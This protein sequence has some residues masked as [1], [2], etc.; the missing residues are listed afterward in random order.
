MEKTD[1]VLA[2]VRQRGP[3]IPS[4]VSSEIKTDILLASAILSDLSSSGKVKVSSLKMGGSPF[5]YCE[6][7]EELLQNH[8]KYLNQRQIEAFNLLKQSLI[9]RDKEL[10]PVLRVALREIKDF[11]KQ[12]EVSLNGSKEIF[13]KWY[14]LGK[15]DSEERIRQ[16]LGVVIKKEEEIPAPL[17]I[18]EPIPVTQMQPPI[19]PPVNLAQ[20]IIQPQ[21]TLQAKQKPSKQKEPKLLVPEGPFFDAVMAFFTSNGIQAVEQSALKKSDFE[22]SIKFA[23]PVG[24]VKYYCAA[25]GKKRITADDL[26]A[27]FARAQMKGLPA[28]F[29]TQGTLSKDAEALL[30]KGLNITVKKI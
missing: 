5:Y 13:W 23:S 8:L 26:S 30:A 19:L 22:F 24:E 16:K 28:F 18:P 29:I 12:L 15:E 27:A 20:E 21:V 6:G 11:A 10:T 2:I 4:Q 9:L 1:Q 7:Q 17:P 25:K 3:I 14:L